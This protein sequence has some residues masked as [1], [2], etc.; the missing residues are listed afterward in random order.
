MSRNRCRHAAFTLIE[1]LVVIAIIAVLI[2]LLLPAVQK[3][4]EAANR[5]QCTNNFKQLGLGLHTYHDAYTKF[6]PGTVGSAYYFDGSAEGPSTSVTLSRVPWALLILPY[7][8]QS[9]IYNQLQSYLQGG[10][11]Y[12]D[13]YFISSSSNVVKT[14][15]CPSDPN[16]PKVDTAA[17][18]GAHGNYV[19]CTGS[20]NYG[21]KGTGLNGMFY[22][23][24]TTRLADVTDGTSNTLMTSEL[25]VTPNSLGTDVRGRYYNDAHAGTTLFTTLNPP[26]SSVLDVIAYCKT[27]PAAPCT[28]GTSNQFV[29]ARS[30][31]PGGVN[32][33]LADASVRFVSNNVNGGTW[34]ALGTRATGEVPVDY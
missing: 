7:I 25:L 4:R 34:L 32:V 23:A 14:W 1:L 8:E 16:S 9:A 20:T 31:H 21:A 29:S 19:A 24:S 10:G 33:S 6:P 30:A 26:N 15:I 18:Q 27:I 2:A 28:T 5:T 12:N 11:N 3:A 13:L 17:G 22:A